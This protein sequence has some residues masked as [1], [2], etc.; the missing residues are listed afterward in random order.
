[1]APIYEIVHEVRYAGVA[2]EQGDNEL[3]AAVAGKKIRVLS[4]AL[5]AHVNTI[6]KLQSGSGQDATELTGSG[7]SVLAGGTAALAAD[8]ESGLLET[9]AGEA[10]NL[11][12]SGD[13]DVGGHFSYVLI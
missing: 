2:G 6:L 8:N 9:I 7:L 1:M 13:G 3:L 12:S 10:L 5:S 4:Y 11:N